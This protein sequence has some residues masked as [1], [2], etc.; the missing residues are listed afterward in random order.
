LL[1]QWRRDG[2]EH[3]SPL[4]IGARFAFGIITELVRE[5]NA[6]RLMMKLDY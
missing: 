2:A 3:E 6:H 1:A 4:E 5:A